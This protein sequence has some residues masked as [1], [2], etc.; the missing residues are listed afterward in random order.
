MRWM[1]PIFWLLACSDSNTPK[2]GPG[3]GPGPMDGRPTTPEKTAM[4]SSLSGLDTLTTD[5]LVGKASTAPK[6]G[7]GYDP[8]TATWLDLIQSSTLALSQTELDAYKKN[9]FVITPRQSFPN[10]FQGYKTIY[11]ADLPVYVSADSVLYA[12]HRSYDAILAQVERDYLLGAVGQILA[13]ARQ[14]IA[15]AAISDNAKK[16]LDCLLGVATV[17]LTPASPNNNADVAKLVAKAIAATG[18]EN[19]PLFGATR[20][21]DFSQF[22][23]RGHYND[24]GTLAQYFRAM[25]WLGRTEFRL[26]DVD[27]VGKRTLVRREVEDMLALREIFTPEL[28][29]Q[30]ESIEKILALFVGEADYMSLPQVDALKTALGIASS[31]ELGKIPDATLL[32]TIDAGN[33]GLQRIASQLME[34]DAGMTTLPNSFALFGQRYV[35]D[36]HIFT[37]V[38]Y[39]STNS[40]RMM[41]NPLDMAYAALGNDQAAG[42]LQPEL[43]TA[44]YAPN[45]AK[46]RQ[47]VDWHDDGFWNSSLYTYWLSALRELSPGKQDMA[48]LPAIAR[49]EA[50]GLRI[51]NTQLASWAELRHD[52]LL[53]AKQSYTGMPICEYPDGY[54]DPYPGVFRRLKELSTMAA[55]SLAVVLPAGTSARSVAYFRDFSEVNARLEGMASQELAGAARTPEDIAFLNDAVV[56]KTVSVVC[57]TVTQPSGWY[58]RLFFNLDDAMKQD[59]TIADV[60]TQPTDAQGNPVGKVL[61]VATGN[62]RLMVLSVDSCVGHRAYAGV[63]SAYHE[64]ITDSF[65]RKTDQEWLPEVPGAADVPWMAPVLVR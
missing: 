22:T 23:P 16:D 14:G 56:T 11:A 18:M 20:E 50:W 36:S 13:S 58:T 31:T 5:G 54:V 60:H 46:A 43:E 28:L 62:P 30:W 3:D 17:L 41:P 64:Q 61:H 15:S 10:F 44:N 24:G 38:V 6:Q 8:G 2:I 32:K 9:G 57:T 48:A 27:A 52:T 29:A 42:L 4:L 26:V 19:V 47:L 51:L 12:L 34:A 25:I 21:M 45:L 49:T 33:Y 7:L 53:Y 37:Q 35:I 40:N 55:D 63:V 39:P 65:K 59:P 1:I